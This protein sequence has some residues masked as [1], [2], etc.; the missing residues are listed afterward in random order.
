VILCSLAVLIMFIFV[1]I[2][3]MA[4]K[5]EI[6]ESHVQSLI[7]FYLSRLKMLRE[8][9]ADRESEFREINMIIQKLKRN[10]E[11]VK[12]IHT[13]DHIIAT[14][15]SD[16]W[17]W[18]KK[19]RFAM[20]LMNKPMTTRD[21]AEALT[22]F[23][24]SLLIDRKRAIASISSILSTKSGNGKDFL[25]VENGSG[26]FAYVVNPD[27]TIGERSRNENLTQEE[28]DEKMPF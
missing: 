26:D 3:V 17:S 24:P 23:E 12:I 16:N 27:R 28:D 21:I 13:K 8:E 4:I 1:K 11:S 5:I 20:E 6:Q 7:D 25:K 9:I 15:Y 18:P 2:L 19:V 14:Q 22:D 10:G